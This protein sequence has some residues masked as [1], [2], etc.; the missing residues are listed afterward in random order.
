MEMLTRN[1][2]EDGD[3][4]KGVRKMGMLTGKGVGRILTEIMCWILT[5]KG[6]WQYA[7][8]WKC[9][10]GILAGNS[11]CRLL[12][13]KAYEDCHRRSPLAYCYMKA[14]GDSDRKAS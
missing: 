14:C 3:T 13:E 6:P 5:D 9:H 8:Y 11:H 10:L 12:K 2:G 1:S 4:G 7:C